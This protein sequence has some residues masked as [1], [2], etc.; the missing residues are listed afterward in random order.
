MIALV[1]TDSLLYLAA[2]KLDDPDFIERKGLTG[3]DEETLIAFQAEHAQDRLENMLNDILMDI[4]R[5]ENNID[6]LSVELYVTRCKNSIRKKLSPEYKA[7]RKPNPI[8]NCL[9]EMYIF[10]SEAIYSDTLEADDLIAIRARELGHD[11]YIIV[12]MDKDLQQIGGFIYNF[13]RK[14]SKRN[15]KG[16]KIEEYPRK[17]LQYVPLWEAKKFLAKQMIMGDSADRIRGLPRYG[18]V[19]A[20]K[21][22]DPCTTSFA[23]KKAVINE[24]KKVYLDDYIDQLLLNFRLVFLGEL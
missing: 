16:E 9:R 23:L 21:L 22:I 11:K 8:V 2:Y 14:P 19:K 17:G 4:A 1:D 20:S 12:S 7:N 5:D 6:V 18:E 24:Y 13:Y 3:L 15:E 10:R